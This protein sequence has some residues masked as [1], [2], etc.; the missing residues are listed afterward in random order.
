MGW[1][2]KRGQYGVVEE[3]S[4]VWGWTEGG[5]RGGVAGV[6]GWGG[7]ASNGGA[8]ARGNTGRGAAAVGLG[9]GEG[10]CGTAGISNGAAW[11]RK[12]EAGTGVSG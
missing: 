10:G 12:D 8:A 6:T 11:P 4:P 3:T 7:S 5:G 9:R 2:R 1:S